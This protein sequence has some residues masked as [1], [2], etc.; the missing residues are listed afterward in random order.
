MFRKAAVG[1]LILGALA[2]PTF[3]ASSGSPQVEGALK[4]VNLFNLPA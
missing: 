4:S 2:V 1:L 3:L